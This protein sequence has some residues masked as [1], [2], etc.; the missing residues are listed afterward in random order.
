V[1]GWE[2]RISCQGLLTFNIAAAFRPIFGIR[3][4]NNARKVSNLS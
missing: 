1:Q 4:V 2:E 3:C